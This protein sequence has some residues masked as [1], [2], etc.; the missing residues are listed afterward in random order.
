MRKI[1]WKSVVEDC[2]L[3]AP[4]S[5]AETPRRTTGPSGRSARANGFVRAKRVGKPSNHK[6]RCVTQAAPLQDQFVERYSSRRPRV[7]GRNGSRGRCI[8]EFIQENRV[9]NE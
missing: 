2:V 1:S 3:T 4:A 7:L 5:I 6:R 9:E 8:G